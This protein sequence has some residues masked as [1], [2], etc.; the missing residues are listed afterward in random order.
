MKRSVT[1]TELVETKTPP[2]NRETLA[3]VDRRTLAAEIER[4]ED[5]HRMQL[6]GI[7]T[8][9][10]QNTVAST[11]DRILKDNPYWTIAYGDV[12]T[13]VDR[14]IAQR[15]RAEA[16]EARV[17]ELEAQYAC[18]RHNGEEAPE[19]AAQ[20]T[21]DMLRSC[22]ICGLTVDISKGHR[23][24]TIEFTMQGRTDKKTKKL[25]ELEAQNA[26]LRGD[27]EYAEAERLRLTAR[28]DT[29]DTQIAALT[30]KT[31]RLKEVLADCHAYLMRRITLLTLNESA[32]DT[33]QSLAR[34][35]SVALDALDD[36][37]AAP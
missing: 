33:T 31:T 14:E 23:E 22:Q 6:A 17:R 24:P 36:G 19:A 30:E 18:K 32:S 37:K 11:A 21:D 10:L 15:V 7:S 26:R 3:S 35:V 34:D 2:W 4:L 1:D 16:A 9:T 5:L 25:A 27:L 12:C 29:L 8:A 20:L 13:A 28:R